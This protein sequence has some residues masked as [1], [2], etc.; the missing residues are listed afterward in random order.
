MGDKSGKRKAK[1]ANSYFAGF[2]LL[3]RPIEMSIA[4]SSRLSDKTSLLPAVLRCFDSATR[5]DRKLWLRE[6][7]QVNLTG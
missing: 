6:K 5:Y 3:F 4:R 2:F 7:S 1:S